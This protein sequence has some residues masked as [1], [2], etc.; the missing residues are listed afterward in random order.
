MIVSNSEPGHTRTVR[1]DSEWAQKHT[2]P[3]AC[4]TLQVPIRQIRVP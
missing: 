1:T 2:V 4:D 3:P